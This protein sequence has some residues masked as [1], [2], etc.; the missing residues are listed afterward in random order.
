MVSK[1]YFIPREYS[2]QKY[3]EAY[4]LGANSVA[5]RIEW[6]DNGEEIVVYPSKTTLQDFY[7]LVSVAN[8]PYNAIAVNYFYSYEADHNRDFADIKV[9]FNFAR[10]LGWLSNV[11]VLYANEDTFEAEFPLTELYNVDKMLKACEI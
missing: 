7:T 6:D 8:V 11:N 1:S 2:F 5:K 4:N 3:I 9:A 10:K